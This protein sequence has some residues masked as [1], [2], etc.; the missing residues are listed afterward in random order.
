VDEAA[1][2]GLAAAEQLL[3]QRR[4]VRAEEQRLADPDVAQGRPVE[5]HVDVLEDQ[6][7]L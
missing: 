5:A 4:A 7:G 1:G 6:P 3:A 2:D